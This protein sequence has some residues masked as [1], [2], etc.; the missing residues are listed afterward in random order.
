M[1]S[2]GSAAAVQPPGTPTGATNGPPPPRLTDNDSVSFP[3][4][5]AGNLRIR[6]ASGEADLAAAQ[7]LRYDVFYD[8]MHARPSP[9]MLELR[10]DFDDFDAVCDHLL[11]I[12]STRGGPAGKVVG[13]YRMLR[14]QVAHRSGGFY[15]AAEYDISG[16]ANDDREVLEVGRSCVDAAYRTRP[17]LELLWR[18]IAQY[19][20]QYDIAL[21]FGCASLHGIDPKPL[22]MQL[23]YLYHYHLAPPALR[24]HALAERRS[25]MNYMSPDQIDVARTIAALPPLVKGYIRVGAFVGDGAVV[26][27]QFNTTD[28]CIVLHT[29]RVTERYARHYE[30][31]TR[32]NQLGPTQPPAPLN[33]AAEDA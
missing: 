2:K 1:V 23:S 8:E 28:V 5:A 6:L 16:I 30:R 4:V 20:Y 31:R 3:E 27:E 26:D 13:T 19:V 21:I 32:D 17:T 10:R 15:S 9:R 29:D 11:V 33:G 7:A 14:G 12:D 25:P 24:P 18:G 22:A